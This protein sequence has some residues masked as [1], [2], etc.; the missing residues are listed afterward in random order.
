MRLKPIP[1]C[2]LAVRSLVRLASSASRGEVG[3]AAECR[4]GLLTILQLAMWL[5][6]HQHSKACGSGEAALAK[7][8]STQQPPLFVP[9][10]VRGKQSCFLCPLVVRVIAV[11]RP[12]PENRVEVDGVDPQ[13]GQVVQVFGHAEQIAALVWER[14]VRL[15]LQIQPLCP[16]LWQIELLPAVLRPRLRPVRIPGLLS[17]VQFLALRLSPGGR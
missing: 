3:R 7:G 17:E 9:S 15:W 6:A 12:R 2:F 5:S 13:V 11:V 4:Q 1:D 8:Q 16:Q 10:Y 14:P